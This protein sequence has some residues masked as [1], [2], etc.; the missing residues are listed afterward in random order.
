MGSEKVEISLCMIVKNEEKNLP[1]CLDTVIDIVDEIIL[2]DTGS[3]DNTVKIAEERRAKVFHHK[4]QDDFSLAR[5]MSLKHATKDWIIVLDADERLFD[6]S[7]RYIKELIYQDE[8][9]G[10][11]VKLYSNKI[12]NGPSRG[13][14]T[15]YCRIFRNL[16]GVGFIRAVH[17]QILPSLKKLNLKIIDSPIV[18]HHLGY[19]DVSNSKCLRNIRILKKELEI[20]PDDP[21]TLFNLGIEY[22]NIKCYSEALEFYFRAISLGSG[23]LEDEILSFA[24]FKCAECYLCIQKYEESE[25]YLRKSIRRCKN[26]DLSRHLLTEYKNKK[27]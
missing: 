9:G 20:Y 10:I 2:V 18:I 25:I 21:F 4:W 26:H 11:N 12:G 22:Q 23:I 3:E 19:Q 7:K 27:G 1:Q 15:W 17:E 8:I 16:D 5:N 13:I 24:E 14:S 6:D